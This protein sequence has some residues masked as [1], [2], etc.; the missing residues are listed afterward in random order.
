M[1][2]RKTPKSQKADKTAFTA[3]NPHCIDLTK[4]QK[5]PEIIKVVSIDPGIR[6]FALRVESRGFRSNQYP[7]RTL[8]YD[9]LHIKDVERQLDDNYTDKLYW[10][11]T[12][13]LDQ[14]LDL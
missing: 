4:F 2:Q 6:N 13:F 7:I 8:V 1:Y 3:Y 14:Y 9:K 5:W 11:L 10:L 12:N